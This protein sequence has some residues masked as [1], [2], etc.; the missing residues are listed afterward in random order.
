M[1]TPSLPPEQSFQT[2]VQGGGTQVESYSYSELRSQSW[3]SMEIKVPRI[4]KADRE[5]AVQRE[6]SGSCGILES[7]V[8]Y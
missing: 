6:T 2:A 5:R 8:D 4:H 1:I 7:S 3:G